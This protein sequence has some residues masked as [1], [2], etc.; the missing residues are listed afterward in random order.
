MDL[1][2]LMFDFNTLA[3]FSR[4][5]CI[6]LCA[7]LVPANLLATLL[8]VIFTT[9]R[10]PQSQVWQTAVMA[11]IFALVM[12]LHV[13]S[14]FLI[15]VV[16]APTYILLLLG[17]TCLSINLWALAHPTSMIQL[18]TQTLPNGIKNLRAF[19]FQ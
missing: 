16:M 9:L 15:G 2:D 8:T 3:E 13:F 11:T 10:R 7:F 14:W 1:M 12:E 5:N 4:T 19:E 18:I 17:S 6:T